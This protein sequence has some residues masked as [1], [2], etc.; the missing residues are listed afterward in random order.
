VNASTVLALSSA[1]GLEGDAVAD[2]ASNAQVREGPL[3]PSRF[4]P[5]IVLGGLPAWE[6]FAWVGKHVRIGSVTFFVL[7]RTVRCEATNVD[8]HSG[9]GRAVLDVPQLLK[10]HFPQHGPYLG[11]YAVVVKG[12]T[13]RVGDAVVGVVPD[14][15]AASSTARFMFLFLIGAA[16]IAVAAIWPGL[17]LMP[18]FDR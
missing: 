13:L 10:S 2:A 8:P 7:S 11:V 15:T 4:R 1:A 18:L 16:A 12:G 17:T 5:N 9:S 6:E 14:P 3:A